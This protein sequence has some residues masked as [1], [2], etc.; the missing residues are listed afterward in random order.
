MSAE[1]E[2]AT[3]EIEPEMDGELTMV[4]MA[5]V[6]GDECPKIDFS[7]DVFSYN[8]TRLWRDRPDVAKAAIKLLGEPRQVMPYRRIMARLHMSYHLLRQLEI[9]SATQ[10]AEEKKTLGDLAYT[11][12]EVFL[13]RAITEAADPNAKMSG[14]DA[15]I[16]AGIGAEKFMLFRGEGGAKIDLTVTV[17]IGEKMEK[18]TAAL[19]AAREKRAN[20]AEISPLMIGEG[21]NVQ[22]PTSN[23]QSRIKEAVEAPA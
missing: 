13:E 19:L 18:L 8:A 11:A 3:V 6:L 23:V 2:M 4:Q 16:G 15:M 20:A 10:I 14:K 21:E 9:S 17:D 22:R 7:K 12:T 1:M 5:M